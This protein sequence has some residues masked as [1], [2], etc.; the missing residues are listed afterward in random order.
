MP[1]SVRMRRERVAIVLDDIVKLLG[2]S[3][4]FFV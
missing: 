3:G 1:L 4:G 2:K